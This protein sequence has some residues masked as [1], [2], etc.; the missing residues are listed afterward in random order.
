[1]TRESIWVRGGFFI[2][3]ILLT[4]SCTPLHSGRILATAEVF[5]QPVELT[6]VPFFPQEEY[7]CGPAALATVLTW[8]G[9]NVTP[10]ELAPQVYLPERQGS[11][12]L[13]LIGAAR[14]HGRI[15]Y[16]LQ[17]QLES[18]LAE[19]TSGNPVL[20]LQNLSFWWYPK[21][22]YA[23]VVGFDLKSDRLVLR[24]GR[25]E[26]HE[27]PFK[28]FERTWRRSDYWA[29]VVLSP[30]RLPFTAEEI[31]YVRA[32]APLERL[33]RWPETALAYATAL[34]RWP[35]SLAARM[36]LGNSRHALGDVRGAEEAFRQ[37]TQDHPQAAVAFN[38]L[39]QALADQGRLP[40]A[41]AAAQRAVELGGPQSETF[42]E[43]LKQ[44]ETRLENKN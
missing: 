25:E 8:T 11:L 9:V 39:A 38:N 34:T 24:S 32:V 42:R 18:L 16:V 7:Q 43:T 3:A 5:P 21:W 17:P 37:V 27:V 36:G 40:E 6:T 10:A 41:Q 15:P 13:E 4:A 14:R 19:V 2:T 26:R 1:M 29:M 22:H 31:P 30:E 23:V 35:K 28:V 12:Q 20:M 44:I 33:S